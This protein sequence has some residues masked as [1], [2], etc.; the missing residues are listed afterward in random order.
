MD[1]YLT[2]KCVSIGKSWEQ[3]THYTKCY[4]QHCDRCHRPEMTDDSM[5][6]LQP[7]LWEVTEKGM[8]QGNYITWKCKKKNVLV[9]N[10]YIQAKDAKIKINTN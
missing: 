9:R 1:L 6:P 5:S 8:K 7:F 2:E 3:W 4:S 10:M